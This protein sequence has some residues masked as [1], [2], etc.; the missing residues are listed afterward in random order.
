MANRQVDDEEIDRRMR[1]ILCE[2][3]R[4]DPE[5][6]ATDVIVT[7]ESGRIT[8]KGTV[9]D[10]RTRSEIEDVAEQIGVQD[11]QNNLRVAVRG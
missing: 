11:V 9:Q 4:Y 1:D 5:I 2:R 10:P 6:D 8:L 3:L 7:V